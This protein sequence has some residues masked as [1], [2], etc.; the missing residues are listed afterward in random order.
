MTTKKWINVSSMNKL[1]QLP[2]AVHVDVQPTSAL[3]LEGLALPAHACPVLLRGP[4]DAVA[5]RL[6]VADLTP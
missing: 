6:G 3:V 4:P 1:Q 5:G 2:S